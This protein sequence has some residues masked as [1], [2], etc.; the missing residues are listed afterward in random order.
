MKLEY[1]LAIKFKLNHC[2]ERVKELKIRKLFP[3]PYIQNELHVSVLL[4][5]SIDKEVVVVL[6][7][8]CFLIKQRNI[9]RTKVVFHN[10]KKCPIYLQ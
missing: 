9:E 1:L 5:C 2:N 7:M 4:N 3:G 6:F 10:I 8:Y